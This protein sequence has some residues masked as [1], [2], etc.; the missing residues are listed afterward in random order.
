FSMFRDI[1]H[2][3]NLAE[4]FYAAIPYV[5]WQTNVVGDQPCAPFRASPIPSQD[6]DKGIDAAPELPARFSARR[7]AIAVKSSGRSDQTALLLKADARLARGDKTGGR[8]ALEAALKSE[9]THVDSARRV[10]ML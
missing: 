7:L 5:T 9:P 2:G 3:F 1:T 10:A 6:I 4:W 8:A